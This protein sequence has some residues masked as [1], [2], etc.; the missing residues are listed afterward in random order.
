M[1]RF[2]LSG[3]MMGQP[4]CPMSEMRAACARYPCSARNDIQVRAI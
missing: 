3:K 2:S 4:L 1:R